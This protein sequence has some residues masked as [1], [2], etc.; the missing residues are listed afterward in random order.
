MYILC[1]CIVS[2]NV[3]DETLHYIF[4]LE[5][6]FQESVLYMQVRLFFEVSVPPFCHYIHYTRYKDGKKLVP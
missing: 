5:C 6:G 2:K 3:V 4:R 1:E